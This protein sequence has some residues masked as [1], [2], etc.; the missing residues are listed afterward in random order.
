MD[1]MEILRMAFGATKHP[2]KAL[3]LARDMAAFVS[4]QPAA[5]KIIAAQPPPS[6]AAPSTVS[7]SQRMSMTDIANQAGVA[8]STVWRDA[9]RHKLVGADGLIDLDA[10]LSIRPSQGSA[11]QRFNIKIASRERK[12]WTK[13]ESERAAVLLDNGVPIGEV[14]HLIGRTS[15]AVQ[16]AV[17]Q[18]K[19]PVKKYKPNP[20]YQMA[21]A[22]TAEKRGY[23]LKSK[24]LNDL[25]GDGLEGKE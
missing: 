3:K 4:E 14:A 9:Q 20:K 17:R 24:T 25:L 18:G 5:A 1:K 8:V 12:S 11:S 15:K 23:K 2:E 10:Y 19:I 21:G 22:I 13:E 7:L 16:G 6:S